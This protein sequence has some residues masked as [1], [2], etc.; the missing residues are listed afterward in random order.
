MLKV[1]PDTAELLL[2]WIN[3]RG[4]VAVWRSINLSDPGRQLLTPAETDGKPTAKPHW[5]VSD[6]PCIIVDPSL[7]SVTLAHE[8]KRFHVGVRQSA[9]GLSL[10]CTD[11]ASRRIRREVE[12][13]GDGAYHVF[14]Y[15]SQEAVIYA[16]DESIP[17]AD[18]INSHILTGGLSCLSS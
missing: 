9:N 10:K 17:L 11:A 2:S 18:F 1:T 4:G 7:I 12:R 15:I 6:T 14:D 16:P 13:A 3:T 5:S 8:T